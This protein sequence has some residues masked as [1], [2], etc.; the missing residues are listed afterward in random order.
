MDS[1]E[2]VSVLE[3]AGLSPYQA[4]AYVGLLEFSTV[5]AAELAGATDVP[6]P[7]I[8]DVLENLEG[9]GYVETY[10]TDSLHA[11][12]HSTAEMTGDLRERAARLE[13]A[14]DEIEDRWEQPRL[15]GNRASIVRRTE[16]V[17]ERATRF[18]ESAEY[19]VH[20][21][22]SPRELEQFAEYLTAAHERGVS[23]R[24]SVH[25][26]RDAD[27]PAFD[28]ED[29][30]LEARH[31]SFP[32]PFV[33]LV[34]QSKTCFVHHPDTFDEYGIVV[35]GRTHAHVFHW[36]FRTCL[37]EGWPSIY[38]VAGSG[39]PVVYLD[40]RQCIREIQPV[41]DA[42]GLV[43][44]EV[45]GYDLENGEPVTVSGEVTGTVTAGGDLAGANLAGQVALTVRTEDGERSVGGWGAM[46]ESVEATR[47]TV[48][49]VRAPDGTPQTP[50]LGESK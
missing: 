9:R 49:S 41:L 27:P 10:V 31:R 15:E 47:I 38:T 12:A 30:C 14:A 16:T 21:S 4:A 46:I 3:S 20:V 50:L 45:H 13:R 22:V 5:S 28:Y 23:V 35:D 6:K 18:I 17:Y 25:T 19:Q 11:R 32:A 2:L 40:I 8:Y 43:E 37:W 39:W 7:R 1:D 33:V 36:Y 44:V 48:V 26:D 34:D 29:V 42:E 24:V